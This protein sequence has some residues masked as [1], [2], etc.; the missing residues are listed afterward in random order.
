M[1]RKFKRDANSSLNFGTNSL[2]LTVRMN[3]CEANE[4]NAIKITFIVQ[5]LVAEKT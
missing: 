5:C 3:S 2:V 1:Q 4:M